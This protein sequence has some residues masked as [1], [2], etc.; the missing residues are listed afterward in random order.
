MITGLQSYEIYW[1]VESGSRICQQNLYYEEVRNVAKIKQLTIISIL[2][3]IA[4]CATTKSYLGTKQ[5]Y[6]TTNACAITTKQCFFSKSGLS[7]Q[8]AEYEFRG[9][10]AVESAAEGTYILSGSVKF[11]FDNPAFERIDFLDLTIVFFEAGIVVH[12]EKVRVKGS[13][14]NYLEFSQ[15]IKTDSEFESSEWVNFKWRA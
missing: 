5:S 8:G 3:I 14:G 9:F 15:S 7:S 1:L 6:L 10:Y 13:I 11:E 12:E 4:S 2:L